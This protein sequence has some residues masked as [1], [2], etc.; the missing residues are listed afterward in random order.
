MLTV[1][2]L[3]LQNIGPFVDEQTIDFTKCGVLTQI[4]AENKNTGG[5]SA[6]GKTTIAN[7][8]DFLL[9]LNDIS[10][11]ILQSRFTKEPMVVSGLFESDGV[12]LKIQ[13]NKK[14]LIDLN[15][16]I[17]TG[18]SKITEELLDRLIGM[19]RDLFR[20]ILHKRQ[21]EGGFFL[22]MGPTDVH[23]FLTSCLGLKD[24]QAKIPVLD[25][26]LGVLSENK[27][28]LESTIESNKMG[29]EATQSAISSL[30]PIP[31]QDID[32]G[33]I[34]ELIDGRTRA[35]DNYN[36][37]VEGCRKER[38]KLE[39]SR[40]QISTI[41]YDRSKIEELDEAISKL[42]SQIAELD[43][44]EQN[45]VS[46][47]KIIISELRTKIDQLN[48]SEQTRQSEVRSKIAS[49]KLKT[50]ETLYLVNGGK[51]AKEEAIKL[52]GELKFI[53]ASIC[54]TCEQSWANDAS[55]LKESNILK[56]LKE[57]KEK[58]ITGMEA[59][60]LINRL[61]IEKQQLDLDHFAR[62]I[63]ELVTINTQIDQLIAICYIQAIPETIELK[64]EV[65]LK[66]MAVAD[67]RME[68][69][70]HQF[71]E[72]LKTKEILAIYAQKQ[73]ELHKTHET[74]ISRYAGEDN[75]AF[76]EYETARIKIKNFNETKERF[77]ISLV[78]L[79]LQE[80]K[81][82]KHIVEKYSELA[83]IL[84]EI[85]LATESKKLIKSYLSC[86]FEDALDSIGDTATDL[87]RAIPNMST[88]TVQFDG[89]KESKEG[90]VK[91]E[92]NAVISMNG[93]IG[94]PVKSLSGG[95]RSAVDLGID[96]AVIQFIEESTGKG[97]D[98]FILDEPFT[99]LDSQCCEDAI[100][101]LK[102]CITGKRIFLVDHNP[103]VAQAIESHITVVRDG[104]T[105]RIVQ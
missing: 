16:E 45:R 104:L 29:L 82:L 41:L 30:G 95:E 98:L 91:E 44:I 59:E 84:E 5:S 103:Q 25:D 96:L 2:S 31:A 38:E 58:V 78:K 88:A 10:N 74:L 80:S 15:G 52:T 79:Q 11:S 76:G 37:I 67:L 60:K 21:G 39:A 3:T 97:I 89:L 34:G 71:K 75:K 101:M 72:N 14:L 6:G 12:P 49:N 56:K 22:N 32:P 13:R 47:L 1:K 69:G 61:E 23:K 4:N 50:T 73:T 18:S 94:I 81:Y 65:D 35:T 17:T 43:K 99:G 51:K 70:N 68:E 28:S 20:K 7:A 102:N 36:R 54:P 105:S 8:L 90:K 27:L 64:K 100:E 57:Y 26:R 19:P 24:E 77:D 42:K 40:P 53:R 63:P 87:I 55:K 48:A 92:V 66:T 33:I 83:S 46:G 9:G 62:P 93:E 86:S 85:E